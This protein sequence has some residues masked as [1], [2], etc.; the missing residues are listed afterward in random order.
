MSPVF[1]PCRGALVTTLG[2][3]LPG[4]AAGQSNVGRA[5]LGALSH[6]LQAVA[7]RV[8]PAVVQIQVAAYGPVDAGATGAR[9]LI[10]TQRSTG[11][12]V[13]LSSDGYI[14]T[15]AHVVDGG[16]RFV[17]VLP[18]PA[19]A[20][21]PGRSILPPVSQEVPA[22]LVGIDRETDLAVLKLNLKDLPF[23]RLGDTDSLAAG[24]VVLAFGSPFGLT[25]SVTMGVIS[26][27][28]RQFRDEDRMIYIQ[29]DTPINPGN[30]GGP[31]VNA[32]G[33]V[34][35]INSAILSQSG[36]NEGVGFAAPANIVRF[37]Y[38]QIRTNGRVRRGHIG[39]FAQTI[40]PRL[41]AGLRLPRAWGVVLGDV[42]PN[43]P[44]ATAGLRINDVILSVDGKPMEN[45]RQF[46]VTLYA[47]KPG[48]SVNL[49]VSRGPQ[50]LT[51]PV[52]VVERRD[53]TDR[54]RDLVTPE[55]NLV[56]R[57]GI[58]GLDLTPELARL[59]PGLRDPHGVVV[60]GAATD[61]QTAGG[62]I[63]GDV[64]YGVNGERVR[65]LA[66]LRAAIGQIAADS[67]AVLQVGRQ[68]QLRFLTVTLE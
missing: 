45:A 28:G 47:R 46:D 52:T 5:N 31:L 18:R 14:V 67:A 23:V 4:P 53:E 3:L 7:A 61:R 48:S 37:I 60:A 29:T 54:F 1:H 10:G 22:T 9:A 36:G 24:Q 41:A 34:I 16:R 20:G 13:I 33:L 66:D 62:P 15:N 42:H 8:A 38:E 19:A 43:S 21:S 51:I 2:L 27:V 11:S 17:V 50:R 26:A 68:G 25:S 55:Q 58:L 32:E 64:I 12:G 6:S 30:S 65:T 56:S 49:E 59:V 35:G 39:V 44:A 40:T 57:L 63:T